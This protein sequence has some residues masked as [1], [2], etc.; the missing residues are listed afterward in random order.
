MEHAG[1]YID[2]TDGAVRILY[3]RRT[4]LQARHLEPAV[5]EIVRGWPEEG[6]STGHS[7]FIVGANGLVQKLLTF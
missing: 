5:R 6:N 3:I 4:E 1:R 2:D 7:D